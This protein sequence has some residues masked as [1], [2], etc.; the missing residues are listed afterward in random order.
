M[1]NS[2]SNDR[3]E[4]PQSNTAEVTTSGQTIA[5]PTV[6]SR[7]DDLMMDFGGFILG[8]VWAKN[9]I[10]KSDSWYHNNKK[11]SIVDLYKIW[12]HGL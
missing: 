11:V 8:E 3:A 10:N 5:K 2:N 1:Q 4:V 6:I 7:A 9:L 12:Q